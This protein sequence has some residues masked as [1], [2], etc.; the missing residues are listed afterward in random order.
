MTNNN[1]RMRELSFCLLLLASCFCFIFSCT[2]D[3]YDSGDGDLSYLRAEFVMAHV[4]ADSIVDYAIDDSDRRIAIRKPF[5]P[6]WT[7]TTDS[8]Y[9]ALLYY[10]DKPEGAEAVKLTQVFVLTPIDTSKVEKLVFDPVTFESSWISANN[11]FLNFSFYVKSGKPDDE[12]AHHS[13]GLLSETTDD[14]TCLF[15]LY[16]DQGG[17]PEYYS[18][19]VYASIPLTDEMRQQKIKL[20]VNTYSGTVIKEFFH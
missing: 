8:L 18:T 9:R 19:R 20:I 3:N 1:K 16:H 2:T 12:D 5:K 15:T 10:N 7:T 17:M 13:I 4:S 14:G 6:R 11:T